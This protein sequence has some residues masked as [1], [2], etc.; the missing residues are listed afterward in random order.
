MDADLLIIGGGI[1]GVG[2]ARDAAGRGLHVVLVEQGDLASATSSASSKL[3]HG[4]L[5][6][7]EHGEFRL[8]TEA[9]REREV[10]L[11]AAP[12][13]V[14]PMRFVL[15]EAPGQRP[16]WMIRLG[17]LAYDWLAR[18]QTLPAST[19]VPLDRSGLK[20]QY[21][22]GYAYSDC[23]V[24]DARLVIANARAAHAAGAHIMTRTRFVGAERR[25]GHWS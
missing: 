4:G 20:P 5:R 14:R 11:R 15:P 6:Y 16:A 18:R 19:K 9:L 10:L 12:H 25:N 8:V 7:L 13:I 23:W 24:D 22:R 3:V 21:S 1:N 2:I 17:L